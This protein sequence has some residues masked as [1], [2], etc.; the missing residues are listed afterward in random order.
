MKRA[1]ASVRAYRAQTCKRRRGHPARRRLVVAG[2]SRTQRSASGGLFTMP[3]I[4]GCGGPLDSVWHV[5]VTSWS[6]QGRIDELLADRTLIEKTLRVFHRS[7]GERADRF[8]SMPMWTLQ[9]SVHS[10]KAGQRPPLPWPGL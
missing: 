7:A 4:G 2:P 8:L 5:V 6:F 9:H 1:F 3:R 10:V